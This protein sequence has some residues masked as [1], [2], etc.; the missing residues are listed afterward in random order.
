MNIRCN[1]N[2]LFHDD[3]LEEEQIL[4]DIHGSNENLSNGDEAVKLLLRT[5]RK[6]EQLQ[7]LSVRITKAQ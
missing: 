3:G 2:L 5:D 6:F 4:Y 7:K 1:D